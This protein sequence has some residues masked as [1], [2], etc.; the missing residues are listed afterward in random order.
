MIK[1]R[2]T[3]ELAED[4]IGAVGGNGDSAAQDFVMILDHKAVPISVYDPVRKVFDR[5]PGDTRALVGGTPFSRIQ[6]HL[7]PLRLGMGHLF[8]ALQSAP[9]LAVSACASGQA[10]RER[11]DIIEQRVRRNRHFSKTAFGHSAMIEL[12]RI[13]EVR[14]SKGRV[15]VLGMLIQPLEGKFYLEDMTHSMPI[16]MSQ[17]TSK[18]GLFTENSVVV[19]AG[20]YDRDIFRVHTLALPPVE[21][22]R[23]TCDQYPPLAVP[24]CV[25]PAYSEPPWDTCL[26]KSHD[27]ITGRIQLRVVLSSAGLAPQ[28]PEA[29]LHGGE[30][31]AG[32]GG[33]QGGHGADRGAL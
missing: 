3:A 21:S 25:P 19:T 8:G 13:S 4:A 24:T 10:F 33:A 27:A 5:K 32:A 15:F 22:R 30:A 1:T 16:D 14:S 29:V 6:V 17:A 2:V 28:V 23:E 26:R 12:T 11:Y 31:H 20:E 7:P 9:E 18:F